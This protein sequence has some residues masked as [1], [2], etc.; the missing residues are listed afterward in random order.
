MAA[1]LLTDGRRVVEWQDFFGF[2]L[3]LNAQ[4]VSVYHSWATPELVRAG[5]L[6]GLTFMVWTVDDEADIER[7]ID[8]G[9]DSICSNFPDVVRR[10][11]DARRQTMP[12]R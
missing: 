2:A 4:G 5:Q 11:V 8:A 6:R 3:S 10:A 7:V 1:A 9:V 12:V